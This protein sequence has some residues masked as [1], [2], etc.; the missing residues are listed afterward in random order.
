MKLALRLFLLL[1]YLQF[2]TLFLQAQTDTSLFSAYQDE[3]LELH[4]T[5]SEGKTE[6]KSN[7]EQ[8]FLKKFNEVLS[9]EGSINY[10]FKIIFHTDKP[11]FRL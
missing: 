2:S 5:I 8:L 11:E 7:S 10:I 6:D 4:K 1:S 3:L 9:I